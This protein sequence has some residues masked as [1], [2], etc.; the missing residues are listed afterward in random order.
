YCEMENSASPS[1]H[2]EKEL[3]LIERMENLIQKL[4]RLEKIKSDS[5]VM[6]FKMYDVRDMV[7]GLLSEF[8]HLFPN[9]TYNAVGRSSIRCDKSWLSEAI[10]NIVKNASEHTADNG[11]VNI[12]IEH[13]SHST[14]IEISDNGGGLPDSE[15]PNLFTRFYRTADAPPSGAGIGLAIT[16]AI[17]EKHHGIITA[18]NKNE[19]LSVSICIPHTDG[20]EAIG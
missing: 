17:V 11:V 2:T 16:K 13:S 5:Y 19:G 9:K 20:Y 15:I 4:L 1:E 18:E 10:G 3:Q 6:D 14:T 7:D 12:F 8:Y